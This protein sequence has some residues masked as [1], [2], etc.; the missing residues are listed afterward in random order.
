MSKGPSYI[1]GEK[2]YFPSTPLNMALGKTVIYYN[3]CLLPGISG[4][5]SCISIHF[6]IWFLFPL[7]SAPGL[8]EHFKFS[9]LFGRRLNCTY[10]YNPD[11]CRLFVLNQNRAQLFN[12]LCCCCYLFKE[13][14]YNSFAFFSPSVKLLKSLEKL[15][16]ET[17]SILIWLRSNLLL[18]GQHPGDPVKWRNKG[19]EET[20]SSW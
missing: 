7:S 5:G 9:L 17:Y 11:K 15:D 4:T 14:T 1:K 13:N 10:V 18:T 16:M 3:W 6:W 8:S 12:C 2:N 19:K 20:S